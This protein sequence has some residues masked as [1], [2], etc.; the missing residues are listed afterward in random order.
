MGLVKQLS[1]GVAVVHQEL[2]PVCTY[3]ESR[4]RKEEEFVRAIAYLLLDAWRSLKS[5]RQKEPKHL[6]NLVYKAKLLKLIRLWN[7][8]QSDT[9][10]TVALT[11]RCRTIIKFVT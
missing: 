2:I 4:K 7:K 9:I 6:E 3:R 1:T 10:H 8:L 11:C 5:L